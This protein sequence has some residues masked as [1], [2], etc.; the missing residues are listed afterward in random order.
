MECIPGFG[1][2]NNEAIC[3]KFELISA[4]L[5]PGCLN[6]TDIIKIGIFKD[7]IIVKFN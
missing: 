1:F 7:P 6:L 5:P 3:G 2:V 4:P